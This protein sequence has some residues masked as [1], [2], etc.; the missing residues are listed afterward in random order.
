MFKLRQGLLVEAGWHAR[1]E[2]RLTR[3][4]QDAT[5]EMPLACVACGPRLLIDDRLIQIFLGRRW[6]AP[7]T[8][9]V[10]RSD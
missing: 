10:P 6:F 3:A 9:F 7:Q 5:L 4:L 2:A 8:S 1:E